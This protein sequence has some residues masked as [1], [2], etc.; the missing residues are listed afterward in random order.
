MRFPEYVAGS[1]RG[2]MKRIEREHRVG[3]TTLSLLN[4]F[5]TT[6]DYQLAK[7]IS[8][9][10][11]GKVSVADACEPYAEGEEAR[12]RAAIGKA[13]DEDDDAATHASHDTV[14]TTTDAVFGADK[15]A[16]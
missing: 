15:P 6:N 14:R 2:E 7:R 11:G 16:A 8:V 9:A 4:N 1:P 5:K 3:S 12:I 10:T 13:D